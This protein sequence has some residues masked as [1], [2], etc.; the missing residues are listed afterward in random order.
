MKNSIRSFKP[1]Y[2]WITFN[3][4]KLIDTDLSILGFKPYYKWITFNTMVCNEPIIRNDNR[5]FKPYYK[6][7]TFNTRD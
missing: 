2:K 1:Y 6:W 4:K 3:T 7:I 5:G